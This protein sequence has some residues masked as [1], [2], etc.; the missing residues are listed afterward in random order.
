MVFNEHD[1]SER[2]TRIESGISQLKLQKEVLNLEEACEYLHLSASHIYKLTSTGRI[3]HYCPSGKKLYFKR[4][5]LDQWL[6][7]NPKKDMNPEEIEQAAAEYMI[8]NP[9]KGGR[10]E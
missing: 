6:T 5:E 1:L 7:R 9:R 3:P 8:R 2:L 10:Y 4:S